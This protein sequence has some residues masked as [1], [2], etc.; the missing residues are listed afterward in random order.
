[1][2]HKTGRKP[3]HYTT[4]WGEEIKGLCLRPQKGRPGR[5]FPVGK[6]NVTFGSATDESRAIH[7]FRLWQA[8][9]GDGPK[10]TS[11]PIRRII[12]A[13]RFDDM[14]SY[15][16][17]GEQ[18]DERLNG[19]NSLSVELHLERRRLR[20]LILTNPRQA[21]IELDIPHLQFY[22]EMPD[23]PN[24]TLID[25]GEHYL[26]N[27]RNKQG[28]PLNAKHKKNSRK[29]WKD[30]CETVNVKY[31]RD[32]STEHITTYYDKV[33]AA[34]DKGMSASYVQGRFIKVK[35]ILNWG[36]LKTKD[37]GDCRRARDFC[38]I[39]EAPQSEV[40]PCPIDPAD[41]RKLLANADTTMKA[42]LLFG[43]NA[44]MHNGEVAKTLKADIDLDARTLV[45]R[46]TKTRAPR[47]AWLW[48]R[49]VD[50]IRQYQKENPHE[51]K[52]LFVSMTG[53][54]ITGERIRQ[55]MVSLRN[56]AKLPDTVV[57]DGLRDAAYG[58]AEEVDSE[59]ARFLAGHKTGESDK[60]V[61]RNAAGERMQKC[62]NAI[63]E[64][65]FPTE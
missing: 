31:A 56:R 54:G 23:A 15:E 59:R 45:A 5:F 9:Q 44:A 30:F 63:E 1:M 17:P 2:T 33:M 53:N 58:V 47:V 10:A 57:Y 43:L 35:A 14:E 38:G 29:W 24:F 36:I 32:L 60:Y 8:Q 37:A 51:S 13:Q 19:D 20:R 28:I 55:R 46:R 65:F 4:T 21:A 40:N 52:F 64:H 22:P 7:R 50:A 18:F 26:E 6:S 25:L 49:T 11:E 61:L 16:A 39:L 27:K 42:I 48:K 34:F 62:C 3:N 41:F 12:E